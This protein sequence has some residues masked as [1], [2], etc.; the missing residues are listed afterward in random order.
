MV[1]G[2]V[3]KKKGNRLFNYWTCPFMKGYEK[4]IKRESVL[5]NG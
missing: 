2:K 4:S 5:E 1:F 3:N